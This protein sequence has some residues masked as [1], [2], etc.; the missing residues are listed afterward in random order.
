[1]KELIDDLK[2]IKLAIFDLDGV[3]YRGDSL[4]PNANKI[5]QNLK[6]CNIKVVYNS[7]NSTITRQMYVERL[8]KFNIPSKYSD[9]YTSA[10]ITSAEITKIKKMA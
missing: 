5:I 10:S 3:V 2:D 8:K 1:M 4:I 7:N 6:E 9:F